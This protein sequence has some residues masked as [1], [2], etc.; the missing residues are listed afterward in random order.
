[1]HITESNVPNEHTDKASISIAMIS[2][3]NS[4]ATSRTNSTDFQD[5][6]ISKGLSIQLLLTVAIVATAVLVLITT[7]TV[8]VIV[9]KR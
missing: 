8:I 7:V 1:M 9:Y 3:N 4:T 6:G 5:P 2:V